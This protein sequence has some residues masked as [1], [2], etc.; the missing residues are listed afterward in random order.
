MHDRRAFLAL[1]GGAAVGAGVRIPSDPPPAGY[2]AWPRMFPALGRASGGQPLIYLDSAATTR[3]PGAVIDAVTRFYRH[4]NANPTPLHELGRRAAA[5]YDEARATVAAFI[6]AADPLEVVFTRGTTEA[7]NL[8]ASSW[9]AANLRAGDEV[10]LSIAE[11][12]SNMVPWQLIA[13]RTGAHVVAFD[14]NDD[15]TFRL[16]DFQAKL[17]PRTR[18]VAVSHVSNV[19]GIINPVPE[20]CRLARVAGAVSVI[21]AAQSVPHFPVNVQALGCDFLAF[22]SHKITGPMGVGVLWAK[23]EHLERMPPYQGGSNMAHAVGLEGVELSPGA[24]KFGAGTPNVADAVGLAAAIRFLT[25]LG[26]PALEA[27]GHQTA[28]RLLGQLRE[29]PGLTILGADHPGHRIPLAAFTIAGHEAVAI[30]RECDR[31][32]LAVRAGD[33][34]SLPLLQRF[35][36]STAVRASCYL[37]TTPGEVDRLASVL[38]RLVRRR[39]E[40]SR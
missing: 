23:A 7:L 17:S 6:G 36:V 31:N 4:D 40:N 13:R 8:V 5:A 16:E 26:W 37:Y 10:L 35:G 3:R 30:A 25:G 34:A 22:S 32:G 24:L 28:G 38:R 21:D 14:L 2:A 19:L 1:T 20:I 11:H 29:V 9:G 39:A 27:H 33:L 18:L 12:A 15:G